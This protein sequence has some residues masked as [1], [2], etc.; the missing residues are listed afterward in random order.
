MATEHG[1]ERIHF[2]VGANVKISNLSPRIECPVS[3][4]VE[5]TQLA[6]I[7]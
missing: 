4:Q 5:L 3:Q 7:S 1:Q 6:A 2:R